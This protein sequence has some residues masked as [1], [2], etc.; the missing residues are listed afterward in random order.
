MPIKEN[1][2]AGEANILDSVASAPATGTDKGVFWVKDIGAGQTEGY[3]ADEAGNEIQLTDGGAL[4]ST[5]ELQKD[6]ASIA[7][8]VSVLNFEGAGV[9]SVVDEGSGKV[10]VTVSGG[11]GEVNTGSNLGAA[12]DADVFKSKVGVDLQ[13][14]RLNAGSNITITENADN[15]DI[16]ATGGGLGVEFVLILPAGANIA[17]RVAAAGGNPIV[18]A[19]GPVNVYDGTDP[20]VDPTLAPSLIVTDLVIDHSALGGGSGLPFLTS[21]MAVRSFPVQV[22]R[23]D[24][25]APPG[26]QVLSNSPLRTQMAI[27]NFDLDVPTSDQAEIYVKIV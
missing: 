5:L 15:I 12:Q 21:V 10:T 7:T 20:A 3:F 19:A 6:D 9:A 22:S 27:V 11:A 4:L 24:S 23:I 8:K 18:T 1:Q 2:L 17:A 13:F 14:R 16:A 26:G 25:S